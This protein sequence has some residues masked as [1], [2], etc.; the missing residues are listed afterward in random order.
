MRTAILLLICCALFVPQHM[1]A[2]AIDWL[3]H[4]GEPGGLR[5]SG[6]F[7]L[8]A[9][10]EGHVFAAGEFFGS[11]FDL[12]GVQFVSDD[13]DWAL[14]KY[15]A[16]GNLLWA[17]HILSTCWYSDLV[18][19]RDLDY[20]PVN[21]QI[22]VTGYYSAPQQFPI[23]TL[24]GGCLE[25][26]YFGFVVC[27]DTEGNTLWAKQITG[28]Q[29]SIM[30][31]SIASDGSVHVF[32]ISRYGSATF[33]E[34]PILSTPQGSFHAVYSST[35]ML[36]SAQHLSGSAVDVYGGAV[37]AD[38][39]LVLCGWIKQAGS[40]LGEPFAPSEGDT[41][42]F[43]LKS[44]TSGSNID[45]I[46]VLPST[47]SASTGKCII[48]PNGPII[49]AGGFQDDVIVQSDTLQ[50][51]AGISNGFITAIQLDG[52][53]RWVRQL[54][55]TGVGG[56]ASALDYDGADQLYLST[57]YTGEMRL[58]GTIELPS[59]AQRNGLI[60]RIDTLGNWQAACVM[61]G[62]YR[63]NFVSIGPDGLFFSC[64]YDSTWTMGTTTVPYP[65][66][67]NE[68]YRTFLIIGKLDSL[69]GF[70]GIS[71]MP[72]Q[73]EGGLH[74]YAN[75]NKGTCTIDL[76]D[77]LQLT[78][79]LVL[80]IVDQNGQLVQR[81]PVVYSPQGV[82]IDIRA[83]ARGIYHVELSDG[84]QRYTGKIVFE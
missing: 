34:S 7:R 77:Q 4:Y 29:I 67:S 17:R 40:I 71:T 79:G 31:T 21:E 25:E 60:A 64:G 56:Y 6:G 10:G 16:A 54:E 8:A 35:G 51:P 62:T 81:V 63:G 66:G 84:R 18:D 39:S 11:D 61:G 26:S 44:D 20:D 70:T 41:A 47:A 24:W 65:V 49:I 27:F 5:V 72:L 83:Q 15:D 23:D 9:D 48:L 82:A 33:Q 14:L 74:I 19:I 42:A 22:V 75:P 45:W 80:N 59:V 28:G 30:E 57:G 1:S 43:V 78:P 2:Q 32:G 69:S 46:D 12:G 38:G 36:N 73:Q 3:H 50:S 37:C 58:G 13:D 52:E 55:S 68:L 76:P 53:I